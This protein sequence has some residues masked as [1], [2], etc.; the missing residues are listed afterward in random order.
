M[1][2]MSRRPTYQVNNIVIDWYRLVQTHPHPVNQ[3]TFL[4][5]SGLWCST[6][7]LASFRSQRSSRGRANPSM[8]F[9]N[10]SLRFRY[11]TL[12]SGKYQDRLSSRLRR[13]REPLSQAGPRASPAVSLPYRAPY[14]R[15][16]I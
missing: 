13:L 11:D 12:D 1:M 5:P 15:N 14:P 6:S 4:Q 10:I 7:I 16:L 8:D 9:L 3:C 2:I